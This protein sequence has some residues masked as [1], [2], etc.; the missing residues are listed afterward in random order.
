MCKSGLFKCIQ[1]VLIASAIAFST[2][3]Y[4]ADS[5]VDLDALKAQLAEAERLLAEDKAS[6]TE[7]AE[8]KR[9]IDERLAQ[10]KQRETEIFEELKQLCEEQEKLTPGSLDACM[11][12]LSN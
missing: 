12:K 10:R 7:T 8:K 1:P 2:A 6:H 4:S 3:S 5:D 11:A 9:K